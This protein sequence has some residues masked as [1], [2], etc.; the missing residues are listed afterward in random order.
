MADKLA[1]DGGTPV[2]GGILPTW[3]VNY[4][5]EELQ[6]ILEVF[7]NG[8]FC[9]INPDAPKVPALEKAFAEYV[10]CEYALAFSSGTTAQHAS[11][12]A[13]GVGSGDEVI[14]PPLAFASTAYTVFMVEATPVFADVDDNSIT[15]DPQSVADA[16]TPKTKAIVPVHWFG[17][18]A[19]MDELLALAK[20]HNLTV[21]EDC[22]HGY[23]AVYKGQ[24]AGT[25]GAMA[26][27]SLQETKVLTAAGEGGIFTTNDLGIAQMADSIRDHGKDKAYVPKDMADYS[28]IRVGNNYRLSEV[29]AAFALAQLRKVDRLQNGRK[30]HAEYLD[31]TL[32][33]IP[34]LRRPVAEPGVTLGHAYYPIRFDVDHFTVDL[35]Q[36][37][38]A[39]KAEGIGNGMSGEIEFSYKYPL[40]QENSPPADLPVAERIRRELLLLP[41]YPDLTRSDLDDVIAGVTKVVA[42]YSK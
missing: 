15:L 25:I 35:E 40:F 27:W 34:G 37:S 16:I 12:V 17:H 14:V 8:L 21:I 38:D 24:A 32:T 1:I 4:G 3:K 28:I 19:A 13:A 42:A 26:C 31:E 11:M 18:P 36:I 41:L 30:E 9:S 20:E 22:A 10:G 23:G 39:L 6:E 33:E 29:H 5:Y 2:R 7:D